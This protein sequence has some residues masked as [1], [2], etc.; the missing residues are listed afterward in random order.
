MLSKE[1]VGPILAA[2]MAIFTAQCNEGCLPVARPPT[3]E[4]VARILQCAQ[5]SDT[6]EQS[7]Q[8]RKAVN[9]QCGYCES[10]DPSI[11]C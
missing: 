8:C 10:Y 7:I 3:S 6:K 2:A 4:C 5:D 11:P 9:R 1:T